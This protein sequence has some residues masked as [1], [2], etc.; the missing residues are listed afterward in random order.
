M[1]QRCSFCATLVGFLKLGRSPPLSLAD[2]GCEIKAVAALPDGSLATGGADNLV[3][4]FAAGGLGA[5]SLAPRLLSGHV[6][7][8]GVAGIN[9]LLATE[10]AAGGAALLSGGKVR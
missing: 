6:A 8:N 2:Q 3:R 9:A 4:L 1:E 7:K 10:S 5:D